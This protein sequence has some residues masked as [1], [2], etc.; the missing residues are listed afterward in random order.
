MDSS[1]RRRA[2]DTIW[3]FIRQQRERANRVYLVKGRMRIELSR[4]DDRK[5]AY[6]HT[7]TEDENFT[8]QV[9]AADFT[10]GMNQTLAKMMGKLSIGDKIV[11]AGGIEKALQ[12]VQ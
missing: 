2:T 11:A 3:R 5:K 8:E 1:K 10:Q 9:T 6:T 7:W 12:R 4:T